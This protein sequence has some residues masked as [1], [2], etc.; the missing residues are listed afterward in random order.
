MLKQQETRVEA[1]LTTSFKSISLPNLY[2]PVIPEITVPSGTTIRWK[3][4]TADLT[5]GTHR[6]LDVELQAGE[7]TIEAKLASGSGNIVITYREGSL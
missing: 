5:A 4:A 6:L 1:V 3:G 2:K 7:N